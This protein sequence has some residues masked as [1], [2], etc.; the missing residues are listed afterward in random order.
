MKLAIDEDLTAAEDK[1][2]IN[3]YLNTFME[4][5][6][7]RA[8]VLSKRLNF[9]YDLALLWLLARVSD[10]TDAWVEWQAGESLSNG[11]SLSD[12]ARA[13]HKSRPNLNRDFPSMQ[14]IVDKRAEVDQTGEEKDVHVRGWRIILE[15]DKL[16]DD[17]AR[18]ET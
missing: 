18:T 13:A 8:E 16:T 15:P 14:E 4:P 1:W 9:G 6:R 2:I 17:S 11:A 3:E 12:I 5:I 7:K 10:A